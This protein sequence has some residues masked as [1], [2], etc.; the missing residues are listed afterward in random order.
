MSRAASFLGRIDEKFCEG[1]SSP[2]SEFQ[3]GIC[4]FGRLQMKNRS[5]R[6][7]QY[8]QRSL[9]SL[10]KSIEKISGRIRSLSD[11]LRDINAIIERERANARDRT[12][13]LNASLHKIEEDKKKVLERAFPNTLSK[14]SWHLVQT[15][16]QTEA[17]KRAAELD[18]E[19]F[20][21]RRETYALMEGFRDPKIYSRR[22]TARSKLTK[23]ENDLS[24]METALPFAELNEKRKA[25]RRE[26]DERRKALA[27]AHMRKARA[28][29]QALRRRAARQGVCPYCG[30]PLDP[31]SARLDH[32]YPIAHG[33]LS[34]ARNT[35]MAC[36]ACNRTKGEL[37]LLEFLK[38]SGRDVG[39]VVDALMRMGKK[40]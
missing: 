17:V 13:E 28:G 1:F 26:M 10:K 3:A 31:A 32:I 38:Q 20:G 14:L 29:S 2:L 33:G 21:L 16:A 5:I 40:I 36:L 18:Q 24:L 9:S 22:A 11:E 34:T 6:L 23:A 25:P 8:K 35:V 15:K 37:G 27:S 19:G 30:Q 4:N 39:V 12:A 7:A